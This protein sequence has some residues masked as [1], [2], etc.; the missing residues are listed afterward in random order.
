VNP[1][2]FSRGTHPTYFPG[3][4]EIL[5]DLSLGVN[6]K[7]PQKIPVGKKFLWGKKKPKKKNVKTPKC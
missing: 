1:P 6:G 5:K 4:L 7:G 2:K 3:N